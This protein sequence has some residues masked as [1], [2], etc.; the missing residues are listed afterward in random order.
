MRQSLCS[1]NTGLLITT[2]TVLKHAEPDF[3]IISSFQGGVCQST[4][5]ILWFRKYVGH[6]LTAAVILKRKNKKRKAQWD[7]Q[8]PPWK[9]LQWKLSFLQSDLHS[10]SSC[11]CSSSLFSSNTCFSSHQYRLAQWLIFAVL[12]TPASIHH[13]HYSYFVPIH[14]K[15]SHLYSSPF[16]CPMLISFSPYI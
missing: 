8:L 4:T 6:L 1:W 3:W 7:I 10:L 13:Y 9:R 16:L 2:D 5:N 14:K 12:P 15:S 11:T